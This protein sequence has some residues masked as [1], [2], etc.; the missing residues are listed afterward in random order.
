MKITNAD[1]R[2]PRLVA[3]VSEL[4]KLMET[5]Y[6]AES[7]HLTDPELL[8]DGAN[9]FFVAEK[10]EELLGMGALVKFDGYGEVKRIFVK[11]KVRG[12]GIATSILNRLEEEAISLSL[13]EMKLETGNNTKDE[14]Q[15]IEREAIYLG[16]SFPSQFPVKDT[17]VPLSLLTPLSSLHNHGVLLQ[18]RLF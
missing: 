7:N 3:M 4:D 16:L 14:L 8:V 18:G 6:P 15:Q 11:S 5:M 2:D 17:F 10:G 9:S 13:R 1:P 12:N